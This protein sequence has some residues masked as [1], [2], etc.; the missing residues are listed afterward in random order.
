[1]VK[2]TPRAGESPIHPQTWPR[3]P[4]HFPFAAIGN[5][6]ELHRADLIGPFQAFIQQI[7]PDT[8]GTPG[9]KTVKSE[10]LLQS[11]S[12]SSSGDKA[13]LQIATREE[14]ERR[15]RSQLDLPHHLARRAQVKSACCCAPISV[16]QQTSPINPCT[17]WPQMLLVTEPGN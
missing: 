2:K 14:A 5:S 9:E 6:K 10:T 16:P 7:D 13:R 15:R 11:C 4:S 17:Q 12:P 3:A 1:M 8:L